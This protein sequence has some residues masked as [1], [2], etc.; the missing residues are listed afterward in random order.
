MMGSDIQVNRNKIYEY[1]IPIC[2]LVVLETELSMY[3]AE[4]TNWSWGVY[5]LVRIL[6]IMCS[7]STMGLQPLPRYFLSYTFSLLQTTQSLPPKG[8]YSLGNL[9]MNSLFRG[10]EIIVTC[11]NDSRRGLDWR[12]GLLVTYTHDSEVQVIRAPPLISIIHR[13]PQHTVS[14]FQTD[15]SSS[16]LP[17]QRHLTVEILQF[18]AL[19]S[20]L[21]R[22]PYRD[23]F[24]PIVSKITSRHGPRR[25]TQFP[26]VLLL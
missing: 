14:L 22:L 23:L 4:S 16:V 17:S 20:S 25:N 10:F 6:V 12:M 26:A 18:H 13:S 11:M 8:L 19:E 1:T 7:P 2:R 5:G 3:L 15:I 9:D 24:A 21:H